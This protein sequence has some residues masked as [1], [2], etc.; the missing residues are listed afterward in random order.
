LIA[1]SEH[2]A[3]KLKLFHEKHGNQENNATI[4][5]YGEKVNRA[6]DEA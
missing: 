4:V 3:Q 6:A 5:I 1:Q 2:F